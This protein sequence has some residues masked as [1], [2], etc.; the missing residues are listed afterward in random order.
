[1]RK[2]LVLPLALAAFFTFAPATNASTIS[3]NTYLTQTRVRYETRVVRNGRRTVRTTY[4]VTRN[5][6]GRVT[7]TVVRRVVVR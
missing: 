4:R 3:S 7:R 6:N 1:M 5:R 2:L